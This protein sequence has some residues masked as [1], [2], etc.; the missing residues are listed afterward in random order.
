[1]KLWH[2]IRK[3]LKQGLSHVLVLEIIL[4]LEGSLRSSY[5]PLTLM[6]Q[7]SIVFNHSTIK[8]ICWSGSPCTI[9]TQWPESLQLLTLNG[10]RVKEEDPGNVLSTWGFCQGTLV[11]PV[12]ANVL[13]KEKSCSVRFSMLFAHVG[14]EY[15]KHAISKLIDAFRRFSLWNVFELKLIYIH[16]WS[17][18]NQDY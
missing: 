10:D 7:R 8:L 3:R 6:L 12:L 18:S 16:N 15:Y 9:S 11:I 4:S 1:M 5:D 2:I 14:Y 17:K 13:C